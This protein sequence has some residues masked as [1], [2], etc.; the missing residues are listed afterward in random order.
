ML[1]NCKH[2]AEVQEVLIENL[3]QIIQSNYYPNIPPERINRDLENK[4]GYDKIMIESLHNLRVETA[5]FVQ[6]VM[7]TICLYISIFIDEAR[8]MQK[9]I[10]ALYDRLM[11]YSLEPDDNFWEIIEVNL[12]YRVYSISQLYPEKYESD[13]LTEVI[14]NYAPGFFWENRLRGFL[15][16]HVNSI[17]YNIKS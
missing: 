12:S 6:E 5:I 7:K 11:F 14:E 13:E 9:P 2:P 16:S 3:N 10:Q 1:K 4:D 15:E 17:R 8:T